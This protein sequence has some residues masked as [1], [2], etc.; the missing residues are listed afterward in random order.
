MWDPSFFARDLTH[1]PALETWNRP[2]KSLMCRNLSC[3]A[4]RHCLWIWSPASRKSVY[5]VIDGDHPC[6]SDIIAANAMVA[7]NKKAALFQI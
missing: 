1:T 3:S 7:G 4:S 2:K 5:Y 6:V